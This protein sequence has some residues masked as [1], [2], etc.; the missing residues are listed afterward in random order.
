[1]RLHVLLLVS[2]CNRCYCHF[3]NCL[4]VLLLLLLLL[5]RPLLLLLVVASQLAAAGA[6]SEAPQLRA[7]RWHAQWTCQPCSS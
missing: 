5:L 1:M 6:P 3:P 4:L 2:A 7:A